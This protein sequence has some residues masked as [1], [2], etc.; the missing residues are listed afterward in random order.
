MKKSDET[1]TGYEVITIGTRRAAK[2]SDGTI[3]PIIMGAS[4]D[5]DGDGSQGDAGGSGDSNGSDGGDNTGVTFTP[6][7]QAH[8]DG[9]I[10]VNHGKAHTKAEAKVQ[11]EIEELKRKLAESEASKKTSVKEPVKSGEDTTLLQ[12]EVAE[13]KER[14]KMTV[15][16]GVNGDLKS[17][18]AELNAVSPSQIAT[19]VRSFIEVDDYGHITIVNAKGDKVLDDKG[20]LQSL[21]DFMV[22]F[23]ADNPHLV[24][25]SNGEGAGSGGA[26]PGINN[27]TEKD[28]SAMPAKERLTQ[29]RADGVK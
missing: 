26:G 2:F 11:G 14:Q 16:L 12:K 8:M 19:L 28:Y 17:V 13:L 3:V 6:E 1:K 18:S 25:S 4:G 23:L 5:G 7:Q 29:A 22:G 9:I 10:K 20:N 24:K 27:A 21:K 15:E